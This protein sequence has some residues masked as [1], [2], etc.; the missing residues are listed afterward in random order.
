LPAVK[1]AQIVGISWKSFRYRC[2]IGYARNAV[3]SM[4][5]T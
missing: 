1:R 4:T 2:A 5:A 3:A